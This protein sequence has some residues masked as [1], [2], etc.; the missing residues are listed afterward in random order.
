MGDNEPTQRLHFEIET[1]DPGCMARLGRLTTRKGHLDT[2]VFMPVGSLGTVRAVDPQELV[3]MNYGLILGNTYHLMLRPGMKVIELHGGLHPFMGWDRSILTDSGGYQVF[4]LSSLRTIDDEGVR[5]RSHIDGDLVYLSPEKAIEVQE[6]LGADIM[7]VLDE[8]PPSQASPKDLDAACS[9]TSRWAKKCLNARTESGGALFGI[10]QGGVDQKRRLN[11][12]QEIAAMS[13]DGLAIGGVS[14]G[15]GWEQAEQVVAWCGPEMPKDRPRYLMGVGLP[16]DI[17]RAV[18]YGI[19]MFDCVVP[20]RNA[21][22]GQLFTWDGPLQIRHAAHTLDMRPVDENCPCPS[23][24]RFTRSYL[25]HL[26]LSNEILGVRLN[27]L[28]NLYFYA[29]L[30]E[31]IRSAIRRGDYESWSRKAIE[32]LGGPATQKNV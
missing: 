18:S 24:R 22:N 25:R 8:C 23:C 15:E 21:R 26:Y 9:R 13:F 20:T 4:S 6:I 7:M 5:F 19:D 11:H 10:V 16:Q 28:H 2:P 12:L 1:S 27:T 14:V 32:R 3:D 31:E 17:L 29:M 30:M